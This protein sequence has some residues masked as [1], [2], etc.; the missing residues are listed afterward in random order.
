MDCICQEFDIRERN[1]HTATCNRAQRKAEK[2][3]LNPKK[4]PVKIAKVGTSN[5]FRCSDGLRV[6]QAYIDAHLTKAYSIQDKELGRYAHFCFGCGWAVSVGHAH[7]IP[8]ARC[9]VLG[10]TELIWSKENFFPAC[11]KCNLAIENPKGQDWK[12][13]K[14]I[15]ACMKFI[16][17][18]DP[19]LYVKFQ[20]NAAIREEQP[21][22][23]IRG[24]SLSRLAK[25]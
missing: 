2:E 12:K 9:K 19:E 4:K 24:F 3:S 5:T 14:N 11:H 22:G 16:M 20:L 13:L 17:T 21:T 15:E 18:H 7:I 1:G 23:E 6:T 10:K 25:V 8:K